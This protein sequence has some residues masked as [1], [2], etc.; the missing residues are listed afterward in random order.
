MSRYLVL[1]FMIRFQVLKGDFFSEVNY[2]SFIRNFTV[3]FGTG[4][5][6]DIF[7]TLV[8]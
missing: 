3:A 6:M 1:Y 8:I 5:K 2:W 4:K 7:L